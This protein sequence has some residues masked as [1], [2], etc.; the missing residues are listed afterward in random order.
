MYIRAKFKIWFSWHLA[1]FIFG[2]TLAI[3]GA[4]ALMNTHYD[5]PVNYEE[6]AELFFQLF[7][8]KVEMENL[9]F[10]LWYV[11]IYVKNKYLQ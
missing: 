8:R 2:L 6:V 10:D 5:H 4:L 3:L 1:E 11:M 7:P 9:I